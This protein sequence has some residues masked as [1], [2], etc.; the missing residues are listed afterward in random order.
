MSVSAVPTKSVQLGRKLNNAIYT[1]YS[2]L[3]NLYRIYHK[4]WVPYLPTILDL[5][6]EIVHSTSC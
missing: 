2:I 1:N 4:Y 3:Q 5:I 6:F